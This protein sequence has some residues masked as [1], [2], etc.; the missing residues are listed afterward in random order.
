MKLGIPNSMPGTQIAARLEL[1]PGTQIELVNVHLKRSVMRFDVWRREA[2]Q[3]H[4]DLRIANRTRLKAILRS[5]PDSPV[6]RPRIIGG[7]F[8]TPYNDDI[9][10]VLQREHKDAFRN[11]GTGWGNTYPAECPLLRIDQI[12][13]GDELTPLTADALPAANSDHRQVRVTLRINTPGGFLAVR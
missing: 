6:K 12:W 8:G 2:W 4:T 3:E 11:V 9:F 10:R 13:V 5:L 7:D 1:E